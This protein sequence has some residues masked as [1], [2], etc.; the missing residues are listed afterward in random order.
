[1]RR[2]VRSLSP[3]STPL[4]NFHHILLYRIRLFYSILNRVSKA[5]KQP[6]WVC[7][8]AFYSQLFQK[9]F[10]TK[11]ENILPQ[12]NPQD[13]F[14]TCEEKENGREERWQT[15][16]GWFRG[17]NCLLLLSFSSNLISTSII[18]PVYCYCFHTGY[19]PR[20]YSV[21]PHY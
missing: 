12:S 14:C 11:Y 18:R 16:L 2:I 19:W 13:E 9:V 1:M 20:D 6:W 4:I 3:G 17:K 7:D 10:L 15:C 5:P 8:V 21:T